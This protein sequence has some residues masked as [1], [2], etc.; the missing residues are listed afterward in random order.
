M[1][2]PNFNMTLWAPMSLTLI[3]CASTDAM[4][5]SQDDRTAGT[6]AASPGQEHLRGTI[7]VLQVH[8]WQ[9]LAIVRLQ[10]GTSQLIHCEY[11]P[12]F[13]HRTGVELRV[14]DVAW[15]TAAIPPNS[16]ASLSVPIPDSIKRM[17]DSI[18]I[19]VREVR[20]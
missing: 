3:C 1:N 17:T 12:R 10:N 6:R 5:N 2:S 19:L 20:R 15:E 18:A 4:L 14:G 16:N 13:L 7:T 8:R 11:R 9:D